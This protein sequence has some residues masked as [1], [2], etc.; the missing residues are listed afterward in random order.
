VLSHYTHALRTRRP[1]G[2]G[3]IY[4][5]SSDGRWVGQAYVLTTDGTRKRRFVYGTT[6]E[7]AH[8]K[9]VELKSRSQ[10]GIPVPG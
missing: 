5:R 10:C 7:E 1:N 4:P 9:L 2:E 3:S 6:W 8:A